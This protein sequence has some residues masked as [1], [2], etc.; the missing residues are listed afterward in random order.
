MQNFEFFHEKMEKN[1]VMSVKNSYGI[2]HIFSA[3]INNHTVEYIDFDCFSAEEVINSLDDLSMQ[4]EEPIDDEEQLV[5]TAGS[6]LEVIDNLQT[7]FHAMEK[8]PKQ[9]V[10]SPYRFL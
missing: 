6:H 10:S 7:K 2:S 8:L 9:R 5:F 3:L 1:K 4:L